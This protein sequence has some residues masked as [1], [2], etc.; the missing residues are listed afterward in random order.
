MPSKLAVSVFSFG[1]QSRTESNRICVAQKRS[2]GPYVSLT[3]RHGGSTPQLPTPNSHATQGP[4]VILR[5]NT[6]TYCLLFF[7][8]FKF[9]SWMLIFLLWIELLKLWIFSFSSNW[10]P[11]EPI[12][13]FLFS[14]PRFHQ[15][16][17]WFRFQIWAKPKVRLPTE[18]LD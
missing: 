12:A 14:H 18:L 11:S 5:Y 13:H 10:N 3:H 1:P 15:V 17:R 7:F 4:Q 16:L 8:C 2:H 9:E 6:P